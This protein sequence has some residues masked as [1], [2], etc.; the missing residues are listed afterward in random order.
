MKVFI[1]LLVYLNLWFFYSFNI[2]GLSQFV[3]ILMIVPLLFCFKYS[4]KDYFKINKIDIILLLPI[5]LVFSNFLMFIFYAEVSYLARIIYVAVPIVIFFVS[6]N[7]NMSNGL[8]GLDL[9]I[10]LF[11]ASNLFSLF[12]LSEFNEVHFKFMPSVSWANMTSNYISLYSTLIGFLMLAFSLA[13]KKRFKLVLMLSLIFS[14]IHF[15]KSHVVFVI[16]SLI[17]SAFMVSRF[18]IKI[19]IALISF[20]LGCVIYAMD[21]GYYVDI[22]DIKPLTRLYSGI[23]GFPNFVVVNGWKDGILTFISE[24]GDDTRAGIYL[25]AYYGLNDL[26]GLGLS[27]NES[28]NVFGG[29][30]YHN[31]FLYL[32]FEYGVMG[33][34]YYILLN[35]Y[36]LWLIFSVRMQSIKFLMLASF[37]YLFLR[38]MFISIDLV[39]FLIYWFVFF[40]LSY[41]V[42]KV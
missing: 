22:L 17:F 37:I 24:A 33:I 35:L 9:L 34:V 32:V 5:F 14:L 26:G 36:I 19:T 10:F 16:L 21:V 1:V 4:V 40:Q 20:F 8:R 18:K 41:L 3:T 23:V 28:F 42:K 7:F 27:P 15:S 11:V 25:N 13:L 30:D 38:S 29:K 39:W 6:K 2:Y 12:Y 31:I